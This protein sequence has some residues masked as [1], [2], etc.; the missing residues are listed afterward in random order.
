MVFSDGWDGLLVE[1]GEVTL[2]LVVV[3]DDRDVCLEN[4]LWITVQLVTLCEAPCWLCDNRE[5][6]DDDGDDDERV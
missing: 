3:T 6:D 4:F 5:G 1:T 2:R